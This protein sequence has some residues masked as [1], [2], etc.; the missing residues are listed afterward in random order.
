VAG[1]TGTPG[2]LAHQ[3]R[4]AVRWGPDSVALLIGTRVEIRPLGPGR[5]RRLTWTNLPPD[6]RQMTF[7]EG[8]RGER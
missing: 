4:Q 6:P 1:D 7:F 8:V 5:P 3:A 2:F